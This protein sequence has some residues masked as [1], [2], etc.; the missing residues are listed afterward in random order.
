VPRALTSATPPCIALQ[1]TYPP[2]PQQVLG[3]LN[4]KRAPTGVKREE[5]YM[6]AEAFSVLAELDFV[7]LDGELSHWMVRRGGA[8]EGFE[9]VVAGG[10]LA[11][12]SVGQPL[13]PVQTNTDRLSLPGATVSPPPHQSSSQVLSRRLSAWS[14]RVRSALPP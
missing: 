3:H 12:W 1:P 5:F 14:S 9:A 13:W 6:Q 4:L 8:H 11:V 7:T 10:W 2:Q